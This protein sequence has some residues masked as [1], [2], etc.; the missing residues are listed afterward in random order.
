MTG[1]RISAGDVVQHLRPNEPQRD[2][3]FVRDLVLACAIGAYPE[4]QG[5]TQK[6]SFSIEGE[7]ASDVRATAD[8]IGEVASY[9]SFV[10]AVRA[11][12]ASGHVKL[13]ETMAERIAARCLADPRLV[14]VRVRVEKLERGPGAVGVE[15]VRIRSQVTHGDGAR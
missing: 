10:A 3:I 11:V 9:D 8:Q 15:I 13:V 1:T 4:E 2:R 7:V 14:S 6:V 5:V 12:V